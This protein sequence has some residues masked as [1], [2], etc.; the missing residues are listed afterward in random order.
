MNGVGEGNGNDGKHSN[1]VTALALYLIGLAIIQR[2][3]R[4][5]VN[6]EIQRVINTLENRFF[7][8]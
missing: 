2:T 7:G 3:D 8:Q 4:L 5:I 1:N 6:R